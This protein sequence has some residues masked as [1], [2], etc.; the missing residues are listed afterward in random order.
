M[1]HLARNFAFQIE[2]KVTKEDLSGVF[3]LTLKYKSIYLGSMSSGEIVSVE[4]FVKGTFTKHINN[5]GLPC[6]EERG[7]LFQKAECLCHYSY[8]Q[9][10]R[11]VMVVDIQGAGYN[12][13]DP[14][15]ASTILV[16]KQE[17]MFTAGNLSQ[18]A[19][20]NFIGSHTCN[21]FCNCL[22]LELL[23]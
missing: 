14:E 5:D 22:D 21:L 10:K 11:Q 17:V 16:D 18:T 6:G 8:L 4:E 1:H 20:H 15:I 23:S 12:L 3:G 2:E 19:I 13:F 7:E 9:S